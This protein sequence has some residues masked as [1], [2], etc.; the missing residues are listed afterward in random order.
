QV[1]PPHVVPAA[2]QVLHQA[3]VQDVVRPAVHQQDRGSVGA[4]CGVLPRLAADQRGDQRTLGIG[5][6][7]D[8]VRL[9]PLPQERIGAHTSLELSRSS[10]TTSSLRYLRCPPRVRMY[11]SLPACAQRVTVFGSTW[12]IFATS[13]GVSSSVASS[14]PAEGFCVVAFIERATFHC[15]ARGADAPAR[16]ASVPAPATD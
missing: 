1:Q 3:A 9:V 2:P 11:V 13:A 14:S 4:R 5:P 10:S 16:R 12:N 7:I 6:Q 8:P 15:G